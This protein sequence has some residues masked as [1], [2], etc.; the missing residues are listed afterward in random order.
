MNSHPH[1]QEQRSKQ[2]RLLA[3]EKLT[4]IQIDD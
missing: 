3:A 4:H 1:F 2:E